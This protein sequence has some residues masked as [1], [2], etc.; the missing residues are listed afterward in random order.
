MKWYKKFKPQNQNRY[1]VSKYTDKHTSYKKLYKNTL[2]SYQ[3]F[4]FFYGTL[5]KRIIKNIIKNLKTKKI[6]NY[7]LKF[8]ESFEKRVD[9][10]LYRAKFCHSLRDAHQLVSH[11]KVYINNKIIKTKSHKL[12]SGDLVSINLNYIELIKSNIRKGE[13]WFIPP[14]HLTI[15]YNTMQIIVG[16][17]EYTNICTQFLFYLNIEKLLTNLKN[18]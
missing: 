13:I 14:K 2:Q 5:K 15:N 1:L 3:N 7:K 10:I 11:E 4:N 6:Q 18:Q 16:D 17:I 9:V 12:N 8:I